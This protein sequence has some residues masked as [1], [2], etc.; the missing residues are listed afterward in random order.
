M[1]LHVISSA[2]SYS[3]EMVQNK[4]IGPAALIRTGLHDNPSPAAKGSSASSSVSRAPACS[5]SELIV[6]L[7]LFC[8]SPYKSI[9]HSHTLLHPG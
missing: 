6:L 5:C 4:A 3:L 7:L 2:G 8:C 1:C 9:T